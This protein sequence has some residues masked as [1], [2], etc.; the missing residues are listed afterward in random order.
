M[1][2]CLHIIWST[3]RLR[4]NG[5]TIYLYFFERDI[6]MKELILFKNEVCYYLVRSWFLLWIWQEQ[7][8]QQQDYYLKSENCSNLKITSLPASDPLTKS[9][10]IIKEYCNIVI[11]KTYWNTRGP[12]WPCI[13][14]LSTIT[15]NGNVYHI[16]KARTYL[17]GPIRT[18]P[19]KLF[20]NLINGFWEK[21]N[22][23]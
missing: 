21:N 2:F 8:K 10:K 1:C 7:N 4:T 16:K 14:H 9:C 15:P 20:Q 11:I 6:I 18:S 19:L 23:F 5:K 22:Y 3:D 13:A 12:W 17:E